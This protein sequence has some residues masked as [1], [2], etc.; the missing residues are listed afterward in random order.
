MIRYSLAPRVNLTEFFIADAVL[1]TRFVRTQFPLLHWR[2]DVLQLPVL[3]IEGYEVDDDG[4]KRMTPTTAGF[5]IFSPDVY[6][7]ATLMGR[8][9]LG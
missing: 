7:L 8:L 3:R 4:H 2:N 9:R 6:S 5:F 1:V